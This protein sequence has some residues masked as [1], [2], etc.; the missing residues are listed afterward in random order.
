MFTLRDLQRAHFQ[1]RQRTA[2]HSQSRDGALDR[3]R[4]HRS[5]FEWRNR[6]D[7]EEARFPF[8][9]VA[10][11]AFARANVGEPMRGG[12]IREPIEAGDADV[13]RITAVG[14]K[15]IDEV[16]AAGP[17]GVLNQG[18]ARLNFD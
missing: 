12:L 8:G 5:D 11:Q 4:D 10:Q 9:V 6:P 17:A 18:Q 7:C 15:L 13:N 2:G 16:T 14:R 1:A 3:K